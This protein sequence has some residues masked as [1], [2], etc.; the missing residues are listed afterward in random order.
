MVTARGVKSLLEKP[1]ERLLDSNAAFQRARQISNASNA[2][3]TQLSNAKTVNGQRFT[4]VV[5][6]VG[7]SIG[8]R[9]EKQADQ[10]VQAERKGRGDCLI[11]H[12][13]IH[14]REIIDA[15]NT[16]RAGRWFVGQGDA[17]GA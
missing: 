9:S 8:S 10:A 6:V 16:L 15:P 2:T 4:P 7:M 11:G 5:G 3:P 12:T 17:G 14:A 1:L 13:R